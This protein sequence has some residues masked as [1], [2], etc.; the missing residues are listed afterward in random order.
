MKSVLKY[1]HLDA[2]SGFIYMIKFD[3]KIFNT[4]KGKETFKTLAKTIFKEG[5]QQYTVTVVS[6]EE[7]LDAKVNPDRHRDLIVR[8]GG[9][10]GYFVDLDEGLQDN[11][12][13]RSFME[14]DG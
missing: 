8:V 4:P 10:S 3:K 9:F 13:A 2:G 11:V 1:R 5:G 12:I 7:L 14:M 6:P